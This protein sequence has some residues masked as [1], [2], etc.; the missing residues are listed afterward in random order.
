MPTNDP[1]TAFLEKA[2]WD[3][4]TAGDVHAAAEHFRAA[5]TGDPRNP[6]LHVGAGLAAYLE[7]LDADARAV[8]EQALSLQPELTED[9]A[10]LGQVQHRAGELRSA[11]ASL[12]IVVAAAPGDRAARETLERWR[13]EGELHDCMQQAIGTDFTVLFEGPSEEMLVSE[14]LAALDR[15]RTRHRAIRAFPNTAIPSGRHRPQFAIT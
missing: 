14:A 7:R 8:L 10:S 12:D 4:L 9:C 2:G 15:A 6:W 3:A 5:L 11:I 1:R 13:R